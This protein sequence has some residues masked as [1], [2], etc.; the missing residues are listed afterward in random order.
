M[1]NHH[2]QHGKTVV[3]EGT[4]ADIVVFIKK[5]IKEKTESLNLKEYFN[6]KE[7]WGVYVPGDEKFRYYYECL[8]NDKYTVFV[9]NQ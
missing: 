5:N 4:V 3:F 7:I 8:G 9:I 6:G 2:M 1:S